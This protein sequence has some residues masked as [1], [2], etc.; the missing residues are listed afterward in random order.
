MRPQLTMEKKLRGHCY[1][2]LQDG[3]SAAAITADLVGKGIASPQIETALSQARAALAEYR[4]YKNFELA[5]TLAGAAL[6]G[7]IGIAIANFVDDAPGRYRN[8]HITAFLLATAMAIHG[9]WAR[10]Q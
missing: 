5:K 10:F 4:R 1:L 7:A 6:V 3:E 2:R 8:L 9:F